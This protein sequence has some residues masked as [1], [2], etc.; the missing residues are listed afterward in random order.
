MGLVTFF[1]LCDKRLGARCLIVYL[2]SVERWTEDNRGSELKPLCQSGYTY[3][4]L[5]Q[6]Y[7]FDLKGDFDD[8]VYENL[9]HLKMQSYLRGNSTSSCAVL[10]ELKGDVTIMLHQKQKQDQR[11]KQNHRSNLL[12]IKGGE[13]VD[14]HG[15][16]A[17]LEYFIQSFQSHLCSVSTSMLYHPPAEAALASPTST[18]A[19]AIEHHSW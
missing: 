12:Q 6:S 7:R 19:G 17:V 4:S 11:Q 2:I 5:G 10:F 15:S 18:D 16:T 13:I 8:T 3:L 1:G 9:K 14:L